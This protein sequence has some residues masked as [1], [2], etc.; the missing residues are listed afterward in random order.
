MDFN[1]NREP[2]PEEGS[3]VAAETT[4]QRDSQSRPR[5]PWRPPTRLTLVLVMVVGVFIF[6]LAYLQ[7]E[8]VPWDGDLRRPVIFQ[9]QQ[10]VSAPAR[11]KAML[12]AAVK[13]STTDPA[14]LSPW[15]EDI[16]KVG[17]L[18]DQH[19]P[20]LDN[21]RDLLEEKREEWEPRSLLWK[22][23]NFA[24]DIAWP[25]VM[26]LKDAECAYLA[27]CGHEEPAFHSACDLLVLA[28]LIEQID[29]WPNFMD[30][31]LELQ[32]H[33]ARAL[34]R[35]LSLTQLDDEKLRHLQ[36]DEFKQW[37]PTVEH[38]V[39]AMDGFYIFERKLLLGP[40][41]DELPLPL[42]YLPARS[43]SR[44]FFKPNTTLRLFAESFRELKNEAGRTAFSRASQIENRLLSRGLDG[45]PNR[46]GE[47]YF[48]TRIRAYAS[49]L[50]R[51]ALARTRHGLVMALFGLRRYVQREKHLPAK[52]DDLVPRYLS[53]V[54]P[55]SFSGEALRY[56]ANRGLIWS[57]GMNFKD[58][59][60]RVTEISMS[61][62]DEPTVEIGMGAAKM[63][64]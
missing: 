57:V 43:G 52:L 20:V 45:G 46:S 4:A 6:T 56:D 15:T 21:L 35:L 14:V 58:E 23:D 50:D 31:A 34:A 60:G 28:H 53:T 3:S 19:G 9:Q 47:D 41:G 22:I 1:E 49:L 63:G 30:R 48:A 39:A 5:T 62:P 13:V 44:I 40:E 61:D 32:E 37:A 10:D 42:W 54:P 59:G 27:R 55:D 12:A 16:G 64:K 29:A 18:L 38:L 17:A 25:A 36:E 24:S 11:M 33:G 51:S 7:D 8:D 2:D 26:A